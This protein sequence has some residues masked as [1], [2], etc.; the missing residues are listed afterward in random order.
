MIDLENPI[1][2]DGVYKMLEDALQHVKPET[3]QYVNTMIE[4]AANGELEGGLSMEHIMRISNEIQRLEN[5]DS[6]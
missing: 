3:R 5:A 4:K 6:K 2:L 1:N